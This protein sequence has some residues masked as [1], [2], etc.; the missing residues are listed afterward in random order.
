MRSNDHS[1]RFRLIEREA[2]F[3][4]VC[5]GIGYYFGISTWIVRLVCFLLLMSTGVGIIPYA[6]LWIF[7]PNVGTTPSDYKS[8]C[9]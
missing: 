9:G 2:W 8:R 6:L 5:A 1:R 7:V 4:G 3:G